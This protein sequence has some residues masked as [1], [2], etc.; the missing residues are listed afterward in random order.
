[1]VFLISTLGRGEEH[2]K[3]IEDYLKANKLF[4]DYTNPEQDPTFTEVK[5]L[6]CLE[7]VL[8]NVS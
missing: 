4:R 7:I 2:I 1:M 5:N 3:F 6:L 8:P